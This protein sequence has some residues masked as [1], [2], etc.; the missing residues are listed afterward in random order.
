MPTETDFAKILEKLEHKIDTGQART[1]AKLEQVINRIEVL[2]VGQ[3]RL[4]EKVNAMNQRFEQVDQQFKQVDQ[5]F[6]KM[7]QRME[8][9]EDNLTR[10]DSRLWGFLVAFGIALLGLLARYAFFMPKV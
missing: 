6:D 8:R 9:L 7:D 3:A 10:Q 4:E 2:E 1:E 5:R